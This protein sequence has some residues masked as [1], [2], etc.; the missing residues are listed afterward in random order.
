MVNIAEN[1]VPSECYVFLYDNIMFIMQP[2]NE[3]YRSLGT[4][5]FEWKFADEF[6]KIA[7]QEVTERKAMM[8]EFRCIHHIFMFHMMKLFITA[9]V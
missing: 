7:Y 2:Y 8:Y 4:S 1:Y 9:I 3:K 6:C 5:D